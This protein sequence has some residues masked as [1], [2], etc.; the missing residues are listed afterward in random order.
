MT[1][2]YP[3]REVCDFLSSVSSQQ[4]FEGMDVK[5]L[6]M[7]QLSDRSV[8]QLHATAQF[9]LENKENYILEA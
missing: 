5:A 7:S 4:K 6:G 8:L 3:V 9:Y 2:T 1:V